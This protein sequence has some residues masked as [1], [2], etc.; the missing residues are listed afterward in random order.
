MDINSM[1]LWV[2]QVKQNYGDKAHEAM[3][4]HCIGNRVNSE[5]VA[6]QTIT[7]GLITSDPEFLKLFK[8]NGGDVDYLQ[9]LHN[10]FM[11][12]RST[13]YGL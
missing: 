11:S 1:I 3:E 10:S 8:D 12:I 5:V 2:E 13:Y 9:Y 7:F 4:S 6:F